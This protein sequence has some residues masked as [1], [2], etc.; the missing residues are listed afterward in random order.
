MAP[1]TKRESF[2]TVPSKPSKKKTQTSIPSSSGD[3]DR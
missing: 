2:G 1:A 3:H